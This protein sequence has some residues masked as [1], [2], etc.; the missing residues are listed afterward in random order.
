MD[1][2]YIDYANTHSNI[3]PCYIGFTTIIKKCSTYY[4]DDIYMYKIYVI[5]HKQLI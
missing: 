3:A 1:I 2:Y 5:I 4:I